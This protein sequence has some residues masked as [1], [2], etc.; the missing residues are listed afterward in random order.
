MKF[1]ILNLA[2][3]VIVVLILVPNVVYAL[4]SPGGENKCTNTAMN[5]LEQIGRYASMALMVLPLG[6]WEF[7][8]PSVADLLLWLLGSGVLLLA[9]WVFWWLYFR[10]ATLRR[11]LALALLPTGIFL[12][13]G[14]TLGHWVLVCAAVIF[15]IGHCYVTWQN[16]K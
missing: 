13:T 7:G 5:V 16:H 4:R 10:K 12:L 6:V 9:Y 3:L 8:F 15:G 1:G 2:N 14:L 11:A